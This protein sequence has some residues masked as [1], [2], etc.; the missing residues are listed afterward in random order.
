MKYFLSLLLII[1]SYR[2]Q[3]Q[4]ILYFLPDSV[5]VNIFNQI[6]VNKRIV[7]HSVFI[8]LEKNNNTYTV[9]LGNY[10]EGYDQKDI[11]NL[12]L[13]CNRKAVIN[14]YRIPIILDTDIAFC[15]NQNSD[16]DFIYTLSFLSNGVI[17]YNQTIVDNDTD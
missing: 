6:Q 2:S 11:I 15:L 1:I 5:E 4:D 16:W 17:I 8:F 10:D 13:T 3:A 9:K 7:P 12:I 14:Q